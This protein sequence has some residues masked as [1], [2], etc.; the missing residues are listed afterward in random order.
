MR[1]REGRTEFDR[2]IQG[3]KNS[4]KVGKEKCVCMRTGAEW[5]EIKHIL[6]AVSHSF[7]TRFQQCVSL[8]TLEYW[9]LSFCVYLST[10]GSTIL[11]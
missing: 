6:A 1:P 11:K 9:E 8:V 3:E 4:D 10:C 7:H 5:T 2:K